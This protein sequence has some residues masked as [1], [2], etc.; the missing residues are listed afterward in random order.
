MATSE[1]K[2]GSSV[3]CK[4]NSGAFVECFHSHIIISSSCTK[5]FN[6]AAF[7]CCLYLTTARSDF[8]GSTKFYVL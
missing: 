4:K 1:S 2:L 8:A 3:V 5:L 6:P 7:Q